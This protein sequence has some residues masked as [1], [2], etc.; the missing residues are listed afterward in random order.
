LAAG[1]PHG[2]LCAHSTW[3]LLERRP[4]ILEDDPGLTGSLDE[5]L[6]V[7]LGQGGLSARARKELEQV[8]FL[9]RAMRPGSSTERTR[10]ADEDG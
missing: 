2:D 8:H 10:R 1:D 9:V 5:L 7:V 6:R 3:A 4:R